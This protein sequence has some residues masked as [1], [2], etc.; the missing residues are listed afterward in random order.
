[1]RHDVEVEPHLQPLN[2]ETF[3]YKTANVQDGARLDISMNS[4]WGV[5]F[6]E[7]YTDIRVFNPLATSNS[8]P[9]FQSVYRKHESSKKKAYKSRLREVE[10]SSFT[11]L[12]FSASRGMGHEATIF[13]KRLANLLSEKWKE[14]YAVVLGWVRSRISFCLL[15]SAIQCIRG[16]R[17]TQG[18]FVKSVG[19]SIF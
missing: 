17:S 13:Y 9:N 5:C 14:P 18:H 2:D 16:A 15:G 4:F 3:H 6:E 10:H 11:P 1:M 12:V 7:C 8:G 19:D